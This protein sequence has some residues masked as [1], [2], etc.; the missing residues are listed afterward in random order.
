[1]YAGICIQI[2]TNFF[3]L[4]KLWT[5]RNWVLWVNS[6]DL[7]YDSSEQPLAA[8]QLLASAAKKLTKW[9]FFFFWLIEQGFSK[10]MTFQ[11]DFK[12]MRF[13]V[14]RSNQ[15]AAMGR[16]TPPHP[17]SPPKK[18]NQLSQHC[19]RKWNRDV[20][21]YSAPNSCRYMEVNEAPSSVC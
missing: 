21:T 10:S 2:H 8:Q 12:P 20:L 17:P 4:I 19:D 11:V 13:E 14:Q 18:T 15:N 3:G 1:M 7:S 5:Q 6:V 16:H 9:T